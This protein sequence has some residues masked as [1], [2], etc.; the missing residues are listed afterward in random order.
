M[1]VIFTLINISKHMTL[2]KVCIKHNGAIVNTFQQ[3]PDSKKKKKWKDNYYLAYLGDGYDES[4]PFI[5][6]SDAVSFL[7]QLQV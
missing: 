7:Q 3:K 6:N 5:D 2:G 1:F 4:D